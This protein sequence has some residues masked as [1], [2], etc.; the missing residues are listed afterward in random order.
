MKITPVT[1]NSYTW[2]NKQQSPNFSAIRVENVPGRLASP[3]GDISAKKLIK[4]VLWRINSSLKTN[5]ELQKYKESFEKI[6]EAIV[7]PYKTSDVFFNSPE[8]CEMYVPWTKSFISFVGK[9]LDCFDQIYIEEQNIAKPII[10]EGINELMIYSL[11]ETIAN[12]EKTIP[13]NKLI[14]ANTKMMTAAKR[15]NDLRKILFKIMFEKACTKKLILP[16]PMDNL[17]AELR[18]KN[19]IISDVMEELGLPWDY[20]TR[21]SGDG[22]EIMRLDSQGCYIN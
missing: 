22:F 14:S 11:S 1:S 2:Q 4:L 17:M 3:L 20:Y 19:E 10:I 7:G 21:A 16:K 13:T 8:E 9:K 12:A 6:L 5:P 15:Y 18:S